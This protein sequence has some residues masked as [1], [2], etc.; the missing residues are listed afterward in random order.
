MHK[1]CTKRNY[2]NL[3][4]ETTATLKLMNLILLSYCE[5]VLVVM[6][7]TIYFR[8][9]SIIKLIF[10]EKSLFATTENIKK[11]VYEGQCINFLRNSN[12]KDF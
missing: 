9:N 4:S 6:F 5:S 8:Q 2:D 11:N 10:S 3:R 7:A 1:F 12:Q